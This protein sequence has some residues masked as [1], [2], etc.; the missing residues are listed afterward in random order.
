MT[1]IVNFYT[2]I[3]LHS[4]TFFYSLHK[5]HISCLHDWEPRHDFSE[6]RYKLCLR[7]VNFAS[8]KLNKN[9]KK[10]LG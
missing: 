6:Q 9:E 8:V 1:I 3:I 4:R 5:R 7:G 10:N 2:I